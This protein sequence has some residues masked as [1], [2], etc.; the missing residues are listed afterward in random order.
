[1]GFFDVILK[2]IGFEVDDGEKKQK[3]AKKQKAKV[4]EQKSPM[5]AKFNLSQPKQTEVQK[6]EPKEEQRIV[7]RDSGLSVQA[8]IGKNI[9]VF[10]PISVE[11]LGG[12]V[13]FTRKRLAAIV[14]LSNLTN[15]EM[16]KALDFL[17]G[18][19]YAMRGQVSQLDAKLYL[20]APEGTATITNE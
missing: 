3:K 17:R 18:A 7:E 16:E 11:E 6:T 10:A 5:T 1:M 4:E 15:T 14:N 8:E 20:V 12:I 19:M 2:S 9:A 13:D